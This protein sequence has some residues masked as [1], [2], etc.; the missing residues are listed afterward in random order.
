MTCLR[1]RQPRS[2][3]RHG[4]GTPEPFVGTKTADDI[5]DSLAAYCGRINDPSLGLVPGR[6]RRID[7]DEDRGTTP[8]VERRIDTAALPGRQDQHVADTQIL[9]GQVRQVKLDP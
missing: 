6:V 8:V 5:L 4:T 7:R 2:T 3:S 9:I 1:S